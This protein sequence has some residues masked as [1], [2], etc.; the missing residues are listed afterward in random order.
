MK[1][2]I[3]LDM[4]GVVVN[5]MKGI[6]KTFTCSL[7]HTE[8]NINFMKDIGFSREDFWFNCSKMFWSQ[9]PKT[10]DANMILTLVEP[11]KPIILSA[12]PLTGVGRCMAGKARWI[13]LN[14]PEYYKDGRYFFGQAKHLLAHPGAILIDD[15]EENITAF[16]RAGGKAILVPRPWNYLRGIDAVTYIQK[17][18]MEE[19]GEDY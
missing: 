18:L 16:I 7:D 9:L 8:Y 19:M 11:Y 12:P 10:E 1:Y 2:Q 6:E 17:R 14:L 3:Y 13:A 5:L 4:D 15:H